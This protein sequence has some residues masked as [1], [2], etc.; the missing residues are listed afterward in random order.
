MPDSLGHYKIL[1]RIGAG[2]LGEV[3]RARDTR[4]GRTV[5]I[6]VVPPSIAGDERA[7]LAERVRAVAALSHPNIAALYEIADDQGVQYLVYEFVPGETLKTAAVGRPM[8]ARH[9]VE[10]GIQIADA[11]ADAHAGGFFHGDIQPDNIMVTPKGSAKI[12]DFGLSAWTRGGA[13]R[14]AA[15]ANAQAATEPPRTALYMSPEQLLGEP[16]DRRTDIFSFGVVL[17]EMLT[18]RR[19]FGGATLAALS[20]DILVAPAPAPSAFNSDLRT[21]LDGIVARALAKNPHDRYEAATLA[22]ELRSVA[23]MLDVRSGDIQPRDVVPVRHRGSPAGRLIIW[24][25]VAF[26]VAAAL[27]ALWLAA[28]S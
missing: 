16:A 5:A 10:H 13:A 25:V 21:D 7:K 6:K 4:L 17:F 3:F 23:A 28:R 14:A 9:A 19:P 11:L 27:V 24:A 15:A 22:A 2:G 1:D 12:L 18:G 20:K 8:N 26:A